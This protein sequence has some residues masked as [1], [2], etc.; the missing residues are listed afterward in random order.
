[1][2]RQPNRLPRR[3]T[4]RD[5]EAVLPVQERRGSGSVEQHVPADLHGVEPPRRHGRLG[6]AASPYLLGAPAILWLGL[7]F[8]VPL[9]TMLSLSIQTCNSI[10]LACKLT[11]HFAEFP[12]VNRKSVG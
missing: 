7:F 6:R 10:T 4:G 12:N 11:W 3:A 9:V 2:R 8:V 1:G 5:L